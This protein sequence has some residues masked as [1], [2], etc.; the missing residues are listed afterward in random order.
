M[1]IIMEF[2]ITPLN[3]IYVD[4][5]GRFYDTSLNI[6][7][8]R[9]LHGAETNMKALLWQFHWPTI[10]WKF[11]CKSGDQYRN[12]C[13]PLR[14]DALAGNLEEAKRLLGDDPRSMLRTAIAELGEE[15]ALHVA[16]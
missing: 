8:T 4:K 13:V 11:Y 5:E 16:T 9:S 7:S 10:S 3:C 15:T 6:I 14:M 12:K 1:V 2:T